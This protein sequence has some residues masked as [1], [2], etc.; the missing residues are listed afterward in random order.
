MI[1]EK[2]QSS[3]AGISKLPGGNSSK[4][5]DPTTTL[6]AIVPAYN[7]ATRIGKVIA[8]LCRIDAIDEIIVVDD[9]SIDGTSAEARQAARGDPRLRVLRHK[10]NKGKGQALFDGWKATRSRYLLLLDADLI[11][12]RAEHVEALIEPVIE[13][14]A[15]MTLGLFKDGYWRTDFSH[16]LTPWLSGQRCLRAE[17]MGLVPRQA[18]AGYG[19]ETALSLAAHQ[20]GWRSRRVALHGV[21]HPLGELP[22]GG[23][24]G[25]GTKVKMFLDVFRAWMLA[26]Y[27]QETLRRIGRRLSPVLLLAVTFS[28][29]LVN[30]C[31]ATQNQLFGKLI[32]TDKFWLLWGQLKATIEL[33]Q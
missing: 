16:V 20:H 6:A 21:T 11:N 5:A 8:V 10:T 25:P 30:S 27:W 17:L 19:F 26:G 23:W 28:F 3:R 4:T 32:N 7:E 14:Q 2:Q 29:G 12:L 1:I 24:H 18:A 33:L 13:G 22:R 15:E 9:G 31:T